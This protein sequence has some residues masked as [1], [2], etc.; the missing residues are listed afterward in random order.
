APLFRLLS[1]CLSTLPLSPYFLILFFTAPPPTEIYT[2]SLHDA[3][4]ISIVEPSSARLSLEACQDTVGVFNPNSY[5]SS[6]CNS[7][8]LDFIDRKSTRL[9]SSH[10]SISYAV[11]C[12]KKKKPARSRRRTPQAAAGR[13]RQW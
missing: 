13:R 1:S 12:L 2:L 10:V 11:F 6:V 8:P 4:P 5:I 3:L 7:L 9:N